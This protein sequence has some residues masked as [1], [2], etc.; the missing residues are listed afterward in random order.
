MNP[1]LL[2]GMLLSLLACGHAPTSFTPR[3]ESERPPEKSASTKP[4]G[5]RLTSIT[6][7]T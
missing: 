5:N 3:I 6:S 4:A 2:G 1:T 7:S